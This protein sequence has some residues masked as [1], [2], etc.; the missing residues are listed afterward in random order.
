MKKTIAVFLLLLAAV[1]AGLA[2]W[3]FPENVPVDRAAI[4]ALSLR[5]KAY[6]A[7][8]DGRLVESANDFGQYLAGSS[9]DTQ[10]TYDYAMLLAQLGRHAEAAA[11]L[12]KLHQ[13]NPAREAAYFKLGVEYVLLERD[14]DAARVFTELQS[15]G[16]R[17]VAL[18]AAEASSRLAADRD[19]A[20]H[21]KAEE[22]IYALARQF[23]HQDVIDAI[24]QMEKQWPLSFEMEMQRLYAMENLQQYTAA[25]DRATAL[26]ARYP[27]ATDLALL[28]ADLL[29]QL[30]HKDQAIAIWQQ[31]ESEN[32]DTS[33]SVTAQH[34]LADVQQA[35]AAPAAPAAAVAQS[36]NLPPAAVP[37]PAPAPTS[38]VKEPQAAAPSPA[39]IAAQ[40]TNLPQ[41]VPAPAPP[42]APVVVLEMPK[43]N[44]DEDV[45]FALVSKQRYREAVEA[46][47]QLEKKQGLSWDMEM[48]RL[49]ALQSLGENQEA[50]MYAEKAAKKRPNSVELAMMRA[51][52]LVNAH[53]WQEASKILMDV[54]YGNPG[55]PAAAEAQRN[56]DVLPA[57]CNLDKHT[58]GEMYA[59]GVTLSRYNTLVGSGFI[60]EGTY[61][62]GARWLQPYA[63]MRFSADT[64][65]GAGQRETI[66]EDNS[67]SFVGG[68]RAQ[69]FPTEYLF[70][71]A[72]GGIN[73]DW[74]GRRNG[75]DWAWDYQAGIYGFKS[76]GPGVVLKDYSISTNAAGMTITNNCSVSPVVWRGD[77]FVDG[78]ADFSY[79][80]RFFSWLGYSQAHEGFRL[81]QFGSD[82][83]LD[84]Y[85]VENLDWDAKG[86]YFDNLFEYG[87]GARVL[88]TPRRNWQVTLRAEWLEGYYLGRDDQQT[89]G[90]AESSYE[91]LEVSLSV[92]VTW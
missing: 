3:L 38:G 80:H 9:G 87:P 17:D 76:Y 31:V 4:D 19:R 86:N 29:L 88:W 48:Q 43:Q 71:Y 32:P 83:G 81:V 12:E 20:A 55:T 56:L 79:Y 44:N 1:P 70:L 72:E 13:L 40:A 84:A 5:K 34:R 51:N 50:I 27:K 89:R 49:Y 33:A 54:K 10:A 92:G 36:T 47:N 39:A 75:G 57:M 67:I 7:Y 2:W 90:A 53:R 23:K 18:A 15:S 42:A 91:D 41:A 59:Q 52:L 58:W 16:N 26:A 77:W 85:M 63:G 24:G 66:I 45:I 74:L 25:L 11:L 73:M 62:P 68:A 14:Q 60:R 28:R 46:I 8:Q 65:S 22:N 78:A 69:L 30:G 35:G 21:Y 37:A 82:I 61:V 6:D 64:K